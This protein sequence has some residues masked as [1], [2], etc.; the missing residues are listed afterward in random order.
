M[1]ESTRSL[2]VGLVMVLGI[3][4][5]ALA[6]FSI[7]GG[8]RFLGGSEELTAQFRH[9]N[10]LQIGAPVHLSGVNIGSVSSIQ[11]PRDPRANYVVVRI[12]IV[13]N[14]V[15]RVHTDSVAKI[16]S[17]GLLGDKF[18]LLTDG[19]P[20]TPS[21][22]P[23]TLL[24]SQ[25]P[26]NYESVLQSRGTTD[27]VA[28]VIAISNSI[29]Q[30]L[31]AINHGNGILAELIKGPANQQEKPLT[32]ASIRQPLDNFEKLTA[33]LDLMIDRI[34]R[35]QGIVGAVI[36]P[37]TNGQQMAANI[38]SAADSISTAS[39]RFDQ[40]S[41]RLDDLVTRLDRANGLLPQLIEDRKYAGE[42]MSNLRRSSEDTRQV[43]DKINSRKGTLGLLI[44]DP[45]LYNG[46]NNLVNASG[47]GVS[48]LKDLY[49]VS[50]P[51]STTSSPNCAPATVE[52]LNYT[53]AVQ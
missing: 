31:D 10:G 42:V 6:I 36:S 23:G 1:A 18:L 8:L 37:R 39:A 16:E 14:A 33:Q 20:D 48:L 2:H 32:L 4:I 22:G 25:D 15:E 51:F 46:T 30:L 9:V 38:V 45:A 13:A 35:G 7:G 17:I 49:S 11:F 24:R 53:P 52:P 43:L 40:A 50:H 44:N 41:I 47:W 26:V 12:S 27:M 29:R 19:S 21:V 28:N 3:S 34:N 5:L